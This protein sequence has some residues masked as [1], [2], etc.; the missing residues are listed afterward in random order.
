[1]MENGKMVNN[2]GLVLSHLRINK[3]KKESG[4]MAKK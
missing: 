2:M 4:S 1:M 3:L